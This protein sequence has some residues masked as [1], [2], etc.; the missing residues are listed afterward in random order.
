MAKPKAE[1]PTMA[2]AKTATKTAMVTQPGGRGALLAGGMPG[3]AGGG[4]PKEVW[5][6]KVRT[7]LEEADG[8]GFLVR[9][10]KGEVLD[11]D[12]D[13]DG[14]VISAPLKVRDRIIAANILIEQAHG[15]PPQDL[16]ID[17]AK[18]RPTGEALVA[19]VLELLPRVIAVLP[20]DRQ[21]ITRLLKQRQ[22]V[23]I[24]M[25]GRQVKDLPSGNGDGARS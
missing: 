11:Q 20:V 17:D 22:Q 16:Q 15:K 2:K 12:T 19:R 6:A 7:A 13:K 14:N 3:N 25:S 24:L 5:R 1:R 10:V 21:E 23:E 9:V 4:R 8:V 18:A